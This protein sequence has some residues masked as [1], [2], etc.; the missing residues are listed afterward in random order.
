MSKIIPWTKPVHDRRWH[1]R[2]ER[3]RKRGG[4]MT[5]KVDW[6]RML[7]DPNWSV[8][9]HG[10]WLRRQ[11][12]RHRSYERWQQRFIDRWAGR[13]VEAICEAVA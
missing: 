13:I 7:T 10:R 8:Y 6:G 5:V 3:A 9:H 1:A 4:G 2:L 11:W 12:L